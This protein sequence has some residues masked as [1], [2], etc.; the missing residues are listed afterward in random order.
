MRTKPRKLSRLLCIFSLTVFII[1]SWILVNPSLYLYSRGSAQ[2][3]HI[4]L[5][6]GLSQ[7]SV[8]CILQGSNGFL[9]FATEEGLNRYDGYNF[10]VYKRDPG[11]PNSL[12]DDWIWTMIEHPDGVLW[13]GT[14]GGG[15]NKFDLEKETFINYQTIPGNPRSLS[16]NIV[17]A[18]CVDP[19]SMLWVGTA[20]GLNRFDPIGETFKRYR[21]DPNT[22]GSLNQNEVRTIYTD[23]VGTLW[24]GTSGGGLNKFEPKNETFTC[25]TSEPFNEKSL[26]HNFV[27][28]IYEDRFG[29]LW[30]GTEGGG[31]NQFDREKGE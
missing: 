9:W 7:S 20:N 24:V 3:E 22:P 31:L 30:I 12:A 10:K 4:S 11:N 15:L 5:E 26:S 13:L 27:R 28:C 29:T 1:V 16:N 2:I 8:Y 18:I 6:Q 17:Y 21:A 19:N 23:R 14:N 25:Y